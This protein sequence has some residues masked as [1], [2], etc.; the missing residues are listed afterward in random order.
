MKKFLW[1]LLLVPTVLIP[2]TQTNPL[3]QINW[4]LSTGTGVPTKYCPTAVI[5][6]TNAA[7]TTISVSSIDGIV[8]N[9]TVIGGSVVLGT[10][11]TGIN[12][13][14]NTLLVKDLEEVEVILEKLGK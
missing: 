3:T 14:T 11:V 1:T 7:N 9:Q 5:G 8:A 13:A 6:S 10:V 4:P 2:Q 12:A